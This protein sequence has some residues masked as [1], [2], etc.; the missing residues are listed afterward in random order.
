LKGSGQI[1][2]KEGEKAT[3]AITRLNLSQSE[4]EYKRAAREFQDVLRAGIRRAEQTLGQNTVRQEGPA[5]T[6][7]FNGRRVIMNPDGRIDYAD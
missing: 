4:A 6:G 3:A 7:T 2:E 5:R 1:T